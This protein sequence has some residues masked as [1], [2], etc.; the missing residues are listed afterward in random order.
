MT[1][2]AHATGDSGGGLLTAGLIATLAWLPI[3]LGS[4][5]PWSG[6]LMVALAAGLLGAWASRAVRGRPLGAQALRSSSVALGLLALWVAV[7]A[8]GAVAL[9]QW[10]VAALAP[11][12]LAAHAEAAGALETTVRPSLAVEPGAALVQAARGAACVA[13][14]VVAA[15]VAGT[16]R[17]LAIVATAMVAV[18]TLEAGY[19]VLAHLARGA[20]GLWDPG[21]TGDAPTGTYATGTYVNRNHLAGLLELTLGLTLGLLAA[22]IGAVPAT[23]RGIL[24]ASGTPTVALWA[25]AVVQGTALVLTASRGAVL[26]LLAATATV[27]LLVLGPRGARRALVALGTVGLIAV[28][29]LGAERLTGKLAEQGLGSNRPALAAVTSQMFLANPWVGWGAGSFH[30]V[31]PAFRGP[32]LGTAAYD[33]AHNDY[34]QLLAE[35]GLAGALPLLTAVAL[36]LALLARGARARRDPLGRGV[37]TGAL[38]GCT[39]L[40]LHGLVDFNFRIPA[41]A[42]WF[43][44]LL[45]LGLGAV[46]RPGHRSPVSHGGTT[47]ADPGGS[48]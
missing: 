22:G 15:V 10:L 5:R 40:A 46:T 45:G 9:P 13:L 36:V 34:L 38:I 26:A 48:T 28:L 37:A 35:Q 18:G 6:W 33:H 27:T 31:F 39:A 4:N 32:E 3:P 17:A 44:A 12:S 24:R 23:L 25:A 19:A 29:T 11:A 14:L 7:T 41:N 21:W 30:A 16:R 42:A 1:G 8:L 43:F 2:P 47:P 20:H